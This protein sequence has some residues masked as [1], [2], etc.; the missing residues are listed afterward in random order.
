MVL[1]AGSV[2]IAGA[3]HGEQ[4]DEYDVIEVRTVTAENTDTGELRAR[5]SYHIGEKTRELTV[6]VLSGEEPTS[7]DGFEPTGEPNVYEWDE[8]TESPSFEFGIEANRSDSRN[9]GLAS[10]DTGEWAI[11]GTNALPRTE[12]R[13]VALE[14][15]LDDIEIDWVTVAGESE[16]IAGDGIVYFGG[17]DR[18]GFDNGID[19]VVSDPAD[20]GSQADIDELGRTLEQLSAG[21]TAGTDGDVTAFVVTSPL[22]LGG[23]SVGGDFWLH[24]ETLP[25]ETVLHHEFA[26][27]RQQ[28]RPTDAVAWTIEG[29]AEY[30][31]SL[32][33][34][35]QGDI[36][37][38]EFR[39]RLDRG[40]EYDDVV[41]ADRS[42]WVGTDGDYEQG[43]MVLAALDG[44][45][46]ENSAN[47]LLDVLRAKN[48]YDGEISADRFESISSDAAGRD[49]G[50]FFEAYVRSTPPDID[51]PSPVV[52]DG[53]NDGAAPEI[54]LDD[55][56]FDPNGLTEIPLTIENT[57]S[58]TSLAPRLAAES[59]AAIELISADGTVSEVADG[60]VFEHIESGE[61]Q[62]ATITV[63]AAVPDEATVDLSVE[64][65]SG[66]G[67]SA[68]VSFEE[69]PAVEA[70]LES[71]A[72]VAAGDPV[73]LVADSNIGDD[74]IEQYEFTVGS[75]Q[76]T[77]TDRAI[78]YTFGSAG[79]YNLSV[80]VVTV[81]GR[82]GTASRSISVTE[83]EPTDQTEPDDGN[84]ST[85]PSDPQAD[86]SSTGSDESDTQ[87]GDDA[88]GPG[89]GVAV[90]VTVVVFLGLLASRAGEKHT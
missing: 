60:W 52:Y 41:L 55:V 19:V 46:R 64:D 70:T 7:V 21:F 22:R 51:V 13:P 34:L 69:L 59:S 18:Y 4:T 14:S 54:H 29:G 87:Q 3:E 37:Y 68:I 86:D 10:V 84:T 58:E 77:S 56:E 44:V 1:S 9:D 75:E 11:I 89:F 5:Y 38:H 50:G 73:E 49:L 79:E 24:D 76:A 61:T 32:L 16:G 88:I 40:T 53:P 26:H 35:T 27:T 85:G 2:G 23:L 81:D 17:Y 28:Y 47:T 80:A 33:A 78:E 72:T 65:M 62:T 39:E 71:P 36:Q 25:P 20:P 43:A 83:A 63:E 12:I 45:I 67:D 31:G 74:R 66:Q 30:Y 15:D 6:S 42:S 57:G 82:T 48:E 90:A 8:Q